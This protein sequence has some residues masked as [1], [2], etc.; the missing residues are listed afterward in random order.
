MQKPLRAALATAALFFA[1]GMP[2]TQAQTSFK[3]L[4]NF[5]FDSTVID[6][7]RS[8]ADLA[9]LA[10]IMKAN[11]WLHVLVLAYADE[12]GSSHYNQHLSQGRAKAV[13]DKMVSTH[14]IPLE[15]FN[16][17]GLGDTNPIASNASRDGRAQNRR[18]VA[19]VSIP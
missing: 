7:A 4:V 17:V 16:Y 13:V 1:T 8:D 3:L 18:A 9:Q 19:V 11:K 14:G 12:S 5:E 2:V 10:D 15:R 6:K